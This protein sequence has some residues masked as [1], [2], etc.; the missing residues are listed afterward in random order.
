MLEHFYEAL[1]S[2]HGVCISTTDPAR[3]TQ[4]MHRIRAQVADPDLKAI[5]IAQSPIAPDREVWLIKRG[6]NA[7]E[8]RSGA[9]GEGDDLPV[10]G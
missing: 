1:A 10:Q 5:E 3:Y 8:E 4:T 7:E 9:P 2:D 6:T